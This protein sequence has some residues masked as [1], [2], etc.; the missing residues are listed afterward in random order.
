[1]KT[2]EEL[3]VKC[4]MALLDGASEKVAAQMAGVAERT[5]RNF[6]ANPD[7]QDALKAESKARFE[8]AA[9]VAEAAT[10]AAV[11]TLSDIV[12]DFAESAT[13]RVQAAKAVVDIAIRL[14]D[15]FD[16]S[17]RV[18]KLEAQLSELEQDRRG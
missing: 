10:T 2:S 8:R 18:D 17:E 14:N 7:F 4:L 6:L 13:A 11:S 1:M 12:S 9:R 16:T 15:V 3:T 5:V